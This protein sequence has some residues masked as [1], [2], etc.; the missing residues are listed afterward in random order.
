MAWRHIARGRS[1]PVKATHQNAGGVLGTW[2]DQ[3]TCFHPFEA[4]PAKVAQR[5]DQNCEWPAF[6]PAGLQRL[7]CHIKPE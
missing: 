2:Q 1:A 6:G 4:E 5:A 7:P 3:R